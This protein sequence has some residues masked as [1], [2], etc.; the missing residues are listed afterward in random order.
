MSSGNCMKTSGFTT[1]PSSIGAIAK[2]VGVRRMAM[3]CDC[4]LRFR[5]SSAVS[6]PERNASSIA[7]LRVW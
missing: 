7:R 1:L 3:F 5:A 4:A 2:P 6:W